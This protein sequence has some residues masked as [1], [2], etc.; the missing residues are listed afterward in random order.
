MKASPT[1]P[2]RIRVTICALFFCSSSAWAAD[3]IQVYTDDINEPGKAAL[4]LHTN[5]V[6]EGRKVANYEG[7]LPPH[8]VLN[9]NPEFSLGITKRVELGLYLPMAY[10]V[11][12]S[13]AYSNGVKFRVK[14]LNADNPADLYYGVNFELGRTPLRVAEDKWNAE[15]R[16]IVGVE[17]GLWAVA[18]NPILGFSVSGS[19]QKPEFEPAI[20]INRR[21]SGDVAVGVE[22]YAGLGVI[23][24]LSPARQQSHATYLVTDFHAGGFDFNLGLGRGWNE[25]DDKWTL[26]LIIGGIPLGK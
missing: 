20:K 9:I 16:P 17:R 22:H 13:T 12:N 8:H 26:K 10:D 6:V 7:E 18:F 14:W 5:Y 21:I 15:I 19:S 1:V 24:H 25:G 23:D 4:E 3:E 2:L 11:G